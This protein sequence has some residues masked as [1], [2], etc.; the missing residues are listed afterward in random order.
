MGFSEREISQISKISSKYHYR[1][2]SLNKW[3]NLEVDWVPGSII[4]VRIRTRVDLNEFRKIQINY[5]GFNYICVLPTRNRNLLFNLFVFKPVKILFLPFDKKEINQ[6]FT[7][8]LE[9][10]EV[11]Q[12]KNRFYYGLEYLKQK[13]TWKTSEVD[14]TYI[15]YY[16]SRLFRHYRICK[17]DFDEANIKLGLEEVLINSVE[18]GN[19]ELRSEDRPLEFLDKDQYEDLKKQRYSDPYFCRRKL[20]LELEIIDDFYIMSILD[21]GP[22]FDVSKAQAVFDGKLDISKTDIA[23]P[24][25][26]GFWI[27]KNLFPSISLTEGGKRITLSNKS[28]NYGG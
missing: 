27:I 22:G 10:K 3:K 13:Y 5:P 14:I 25:G 1:I 4:F 28:I 7:N 23:S 19:L 2:V 6:I 26:K 8:M 16:F 18:H 20:V 15:A 12:G 9:E 24:G 21:E 17:N 11:A